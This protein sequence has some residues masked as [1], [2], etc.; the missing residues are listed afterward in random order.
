[1]RLVFILWKFRACSPRPLQNY[2]PTKLYTDEH[3]PACGQLIG[4][5]SPR[6]WAWYAPDPLTRQL[7]SVTWTSPR[8][9]KKTI[10]QAQS[11]IGTD[12]LLP[13]NQDHLI[14]GHSTL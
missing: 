2:N 14:R 6:L 7:G 9:K 8:A 3:S 10:E 13:L 1:M 5:E 11:L 12:H 4:V